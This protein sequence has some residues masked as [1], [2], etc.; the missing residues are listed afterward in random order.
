[1]KTSKN[2]F[3]VMAVFVIIVESLSCEA[4][5]RLYQFHELEKDRDRLQNQKP[6]TNTN[7]IQTIPIHV[8]A[9][10]FDPSS[11][12]GHPAFFHDLILQNYTENENGYYILQFQRPLRQQWSET[13][14]KLRLKIPTN[15]IGSLSRLTGIKF[16]E[17]VPEFKLSPAVKKK[18]GGQ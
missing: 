7:L 4:A 18:G 5:N 9:G 11:E 1:V 6:I 8:D 17:R 16:I 12:D 2:L 13:N 3:G 10:S 15:K 14:K